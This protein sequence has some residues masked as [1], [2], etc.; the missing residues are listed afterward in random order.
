MRD[1]KV[2]AVFLVL[3]ILLSG[4]QNGD[5]PGKTSDIDDVKTWFE[6]YA[7]DY[8][9]VDVQT[10]ESGKYIL[11]T[12]FT[13]PG[14]TEHYTMVRAYVVRKDKNSYAVDAIKDAYEAGSVGFSAEL[15]GV[16][17]VA[18]IFGDI[19]NSLY[20]FKTD[21][22][23]EVS[24]TEVVVKTSDGEEKTIS[25]TNDK[26]YIGIIGVD[27]EIT[28]IIFKTDIGDINFSDYYSEPL[29]FSPD[30]T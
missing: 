24:F 15:L 28:D 26:P 17:D 18:V 20:D 27:T 25:V 29:D 1:V 14:E 7:S 21:T 9:I 12:T 6:G 19:G 2:A 3:L 4:C 10:H 13:P 22:V 8:E 23:Q 30:N 16:E 5:K 11:L